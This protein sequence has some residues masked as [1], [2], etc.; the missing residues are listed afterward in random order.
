MEPRHLCRIATVIGLAIL[1]CACF[2]GPLLAAEA[3]DSLGEYLG[4]QA[5]AVSNDG[6]TL[7][8]ACADARQVAWIELSRGVV[9]RRVAVPAEP[10]GLALSRDGTR[11]FVTCAAAKSTVVVLDAATGDQLAA[12]PAGHTAMSPVLSPDEITLYVC[13]RFDNN[14]SVIDLASGLELAWVPAVREPVAAAMTPDGYYL[15]VANHLP[16]MP[17]DDPLHFDVNP[18]VTRIDTETLQATSIPLPHG[19]NG[20]RGICAAPDGRHVLV[21][22]LQSNFQEIPFRVDGGWINVNV[23]SIIDT[24]ERKV[25]ATIGMDENFRGAGNPYD[26]VFSA[27][28]RTVCVSLAGTGE[29]CLIDAADLFGKFAR[30]TMQPMMGVWPIYVGLGSSLWRRSSLPGVGPRG[31]AVSGSKVYAAEYFSDTVAVV[32]LASPPETAATEIPLGPEPRLTTERWGELLFHDATICYDHWQSCASCHP[33]GRA[34]G[35][36]WDLENDGSGNPKNTKSMLL[37][38]VTPPAMAEGVRASAEVAVRSG[39]NHILFAYRP[40]EEEEAAAIDAYLK[41]LRPVPSPRLADGR[42]SPSAKRG[43]EL[44]ES[45]RVGC[46]RCHPAPLYTDLKS[47]DVASRG[48]RDRNDRFDTPTLVEVWRTAPYLH[49]GRYATVRELLVEGKHG[50]PAELSDAEIDDLVEFVLSL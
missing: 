23:V 7:Y 11:L 26:V 48:P 13:N 2:G 10:T 15:Y 46:A 6:R 27:D 5:M 49:D 42:L 47:H 8:V 36:N 38:H 39:L 14:V 31:L 35:L 41:S 32:D 33:D 25:V 4:P 30:Q 19:S 21:A 29:L 17:T 44:F 37:A 9:A 1:C 28:G 18:I 20:L 24:R 40:D 22:H 34:D 43:R 45:E 16:D 50:R 12:M 3:P